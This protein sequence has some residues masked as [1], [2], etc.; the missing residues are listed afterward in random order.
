MVEEQQNLQSRFLLSF[1]HVGPGV[2]CGKMFASG[3]LR[4]L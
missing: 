1:E 3:P 2:E 4:D